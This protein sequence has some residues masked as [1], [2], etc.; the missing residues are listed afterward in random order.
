MILILTRNSP[1]ADSVLT[2]DRE[3]KKWKR[4]TKYKSGRER[5][6]D[7]VYPKFKDFFLK[8]IRNGYVLIEGT[9]DE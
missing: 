6:R 8:Q 4:E 3:F 1:T 7:G 5:F 2:I 9:I